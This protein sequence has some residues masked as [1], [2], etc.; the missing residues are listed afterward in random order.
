MSPSDS[1]HLELRVAEG[2]LLRCYNRASDREDDDVYTMAEVS[3][4]HSYK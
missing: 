1:P 3:I 2:N 4:L